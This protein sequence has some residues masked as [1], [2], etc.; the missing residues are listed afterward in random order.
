MAVIRE[1]GHEPDSCDLV[2]VADRPHVAGRRQ[3]IRD[4]LAS[5][6]SVDPSRVSVKGSRPEGLGLTGDGAACFAV[7][8]I[9]ST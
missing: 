7:A 5:V 2:V 8:T 4:R 3:E 6:L 1:A 9:R